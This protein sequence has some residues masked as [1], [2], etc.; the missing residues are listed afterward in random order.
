M[1]E[2]FSKQGRCE[3]FWGN[4]M[5]GTGNSNWKGPGARRYM[6]G[7]SYSMWPSVVPVGGYRESEESEVAG[8][9]WNG[10]QRP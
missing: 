10:S 8:T 3:V 2:V 1:S 5:L 6:L 9:I 4:R 7:L